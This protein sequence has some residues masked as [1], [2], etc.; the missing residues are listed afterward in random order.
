MNRRGFLK[1]AI[2]GTTAALVAPALLKSEPPK[3]KLSDEEALKNLVDEKMDS[4]QRRLTEQF[5]RSMIYHT[6]QMGK[7]NFNHHAMLK[8][9]IDNPHKTILPIPTK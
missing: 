9:I 1:R 7:T 5:N 4:M 2:L 8:H 3:P 6:R